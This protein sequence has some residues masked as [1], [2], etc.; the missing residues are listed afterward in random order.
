M[1]HGFTLTELLTSI[2]IFALLATVTVAAYRGGDDQTELR[3]AT[4]LLANLMRDAQSRSQAGRVALVCTG[5]G[6]VCTASC[7]VPCADEFPVGGYGVHVGLGESSAILFAD[8]G[9]APNMLRDLSEDIETVPFT[10]GGRV[11]V[12][13]ITETLPGGKGSPSVGD[14]VFIP[15]RPMARANANT[16]VSELQ[17]TLRH[18]RTGAERTVVVNAV[19]GLVSE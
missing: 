3:H 6:A 2:G 17:I 14:V 18:A 10:R 16:D 12:N 9:A 5:A 19:S 8:L 4:D 15:P 7:A 11:S 13:A 1:R